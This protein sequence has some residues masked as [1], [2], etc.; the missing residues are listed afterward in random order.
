MPPPDD[1]DKA[2]SLAAH[3]GPRIP[4]APQRLT[5]RG[6]RQLTEAEAR[7]L[8]GSSAH[9]GWSCEVDFDDDAAI[10]LLPSFAIDTFAYSPWWNQSCSGNYARVA[11][12]DDHHFHL[13]YADPDVSTCLDADNPYDT[14]VGAWSK[15]DDCAPLDPLTEPRGYVLPHTPWNHLRLDRID[16]YGSDYTPRPFT[17]E[18]VRVVNAA[19]KVCYRMPPQGPWEAAAPAG[20]FDEPGLVYCWAALDPGYWDLS[21]WTVGT[22]GVT[23]TEGEDAIW[24]VDDIRMG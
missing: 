11:P 1:D 20:P 14:P 3:L 18:R 16:G 7:S 24:G 15:G 21:D 12:T 9:G 2:V 19:A 17:L 23:F 22:V 5:A 6:L 8:T 4:A 10:A 13:G